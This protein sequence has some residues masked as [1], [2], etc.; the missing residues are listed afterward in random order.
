[1]K[2]LNI[3]FLCLWSLIIISCKNNSVNTT[4]LLAERDSLRN[5]N[6][7]QEEELN[8]LTSVMNSIYTTV[9]SITQQEK[10][11]YIA[12]ENNVCNK[13][14]LMEQLTFLG[15]LLERQRKVIKQLSDS[16]VSDSLNMIPSKKK[17]LS[18]I[19]FLE[20]QL[21]EKDI[22]INNLRRE[23]SRNNTS[24]AQLK[25]TVINLETNISD[26]TEK[27]DAQLKALEVQNKM[28]NMGYFIVG[29]KNELKE[30]GIIRT[31]LFSTK[32]DINPSHIDK[33]TAVDLRNFNEITIKS[34][35]MKVLSQMPKSSYYVKNNND[36][37]STLVIT[38][39]DEF[40]RFSN[41]LVIQSYK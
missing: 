1:M 19:S 35:K 23:I 25:K 20:T 29:T 40:W 14:L 34:K 39:T 2:A 11:I 7:K 5:I 22:T 16:L 41:Y 37:T 21:E 27:N 33:F 31:N 9:D 24:I 3:L 26:L 28:L 38:D 30:A 13:K 12:R 8:M 6:Y 36:N 18:I 15:E 10:Y 17:L 4:S 32:L